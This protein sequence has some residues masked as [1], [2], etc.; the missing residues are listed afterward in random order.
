MYFS[1]RGIVRPSRFRRGAKCTAQ[2]GPMHPLTGTCPGIQVLTP[3]RLKWANF[4]HFSY[5]SP[6]MDRCSPS[7][8]SC[9]R[10]QRGAGP[11]KSRAL[12]WGCAHPR[13]G[14]SRGHRARDIHRRPVIALASGSPSTCPAWFK[15][16]EGMAFPTESPCHSAGVNA[17][18]AQSA[19]P[20]Q[21]T[22]P[23]ECNSCNTIPT[24]RLTPS[25]NKVTAGIVLQNPKS[26]P[27]PG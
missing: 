8:N 27:I 13:P 24:I 3:I 19:T 5:E 10:L 15:R 22:P 26:R 9:T 6:A 4:P 1:N 7:L 17:C 2:T 21:V 16:T 23:Q 20:A 14:A 25:V 11:R 12:K 18:H